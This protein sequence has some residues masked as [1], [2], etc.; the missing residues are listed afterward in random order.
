MVILFGDTNS[1]LAG[2]VAAS[3]YQCEIVHV[4]AGLRSYNKLMPEEH[5]RIVADH[6]S[7]ILC[8]T[9]EEPKTNLLKEGISHKKIFLTGDIMLDTFKKNKQK[10]FSEN[11]YEKIGYKKNAYILCTVHRRENII[12]EEKL[13]NIFKALNMISEQ[14][15]PVILPIHPATKKYLDLL[16]LNISSI[17]IVNPYEYIKFLSLVDGANFVITDS[18]GLQKDAYYLKK[19][20][21]VFRNESEWPELADNNASILVDPLNFDAI[22]NNVNL[23]I[24]TKIKNK[25][26]YGNGTTAK[27]INKIIKQFLSK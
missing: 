10:I 3:S 6:L 4:E 25:N 5:N 13:F 14:I 8:V 2:A 26:L 17:K 24:D 9:S 23:L 11:A 18:G 20:T 27:Q 21:L 12:D 16:N 15:M 7:T 19:K 22:I 1:T